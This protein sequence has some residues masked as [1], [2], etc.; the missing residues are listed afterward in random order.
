MTSKEI[1][2]KYI[3]FFVQKGHAQ[4]P[5]APL[6]PEHDP[7]VLF[8]TAGMHPLVPFLMGEPHPAGKRLVNFQKCVRTQDIDEVGDATHDTFFE[9]L[10]NWSLGD[11]FKKEAIQWS[12]EFL[13]S[14]HWLG[15]HPSRIYVTVFAGDDDAPRDQEAA[16]VWESVGVPHHRIQFKGKSQNWWGPAGETGPCGPDTEMF[17]YAGEGETPEGIDPTEDTRFVEVWNDVFM[18]YEKR[19]DGSFV[20]L[21]QQNVDTGMGLERA[22]MILQGKTSIFETDLFAP[23]VARIQQ[24][25]SVTASPETLRSLRIVVD[26]TRTAI[27]MMADEVQPS[28]TDRGYILRRLIRRAI[29]H[30]RALGVD[31]RVLPELIDDVV[32]IYGE[33]YPEIPRRKKAIYTILL[34]ESVKFQ[35]TLEKGLKE[36]EL[37]AARNIDEVI[38]GK[39]AF[40]L[41]STYGFPLEMTKELAAKQHRSVDE[42]AFWKEFEAHQQLSRKGAEQKFHGGLADH[43]V[44]SIMLHTATHLLHQALK[45]VLGEKVNQKGSNI[46]KDRLRFDFN[47]DAKLTPEQITRVE[48]IVNEQITRD[49]PV[50]WEEMTVPEAKQRGAIGL[51][52][53]RYGERV[54]I[55][56]MGDYSKEVCG[57]P[58]VPHTGLLKDFTITKEE[59]VGAGLRR[60]KAIVGGLSDAPSLTSFVPAGPLKK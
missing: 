1:R 49:L 17:V 52:D 43:S 47:W 21:A 36:F 15:I 31:A 54:K 53:E 13:T 29:Q 44:Q 7:T 42:R 22:A 46:T 37:I 34:E 40:L 48:Q 41:F 23:L 45:D 11:Y 26:H 30:A 9:M 50:H 10:G 24:E 28:N 38:S 18:Q 35:K 39:E 58:H 2:K 20:P 32:N 51:F 56:I 6:V 33:T 60:I 25:M 55:Y 59:A 16:D 4:I 5:S 14:P 19:N 57:G 12:W 27:F 3:E 8:T